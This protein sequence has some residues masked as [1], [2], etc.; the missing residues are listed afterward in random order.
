VTP[1]PCLSDQ[2][3]LAELPPQ[4][5]QGA[6]HQ[7]QPSHCVWRPLQARRR[8]VGPQCSQG[9][10]ILRA[11]VC[12]YVCL[13]LCVCVCVYVCACLRCECLRGRRSIDLPLTAA[14][15][16]A[17]LPLLRCKRAAC[18]EDAPAVLHAAAMDNQN[19]GPLSRQDIRRAPHLATARLAE[20]LRDDAPLLQRRAP[21]GFRR[22]S[23]GRPHHTFPV[24]RLPAGRHSLRGHP[25]SL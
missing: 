9:G 25:C 14:L 19:H 22:A 11:H 24:S 12:E 3:L 6:S 2:Q 18:G 10:C 16:S 8:A 21:D 7:P 15:V 20:R 5:P 1:L 13:C 4:L 17:H 23:Q